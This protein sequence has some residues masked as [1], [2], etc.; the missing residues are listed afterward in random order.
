MAQALL[1]P[2]SL[3]NSSTDVRRTSSTTSAIFG[4]KLRLLEIEQTHL[5]FSNS[6][7]KYIHFK[8]TD[9]HAT[10]GIDPKR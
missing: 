3:S 4:S 6:S 7:K 5:R 2:S 1:P 10:F 9:I 8:I